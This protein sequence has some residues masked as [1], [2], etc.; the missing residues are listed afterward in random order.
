M[1]KVYINGRFLAEYLTGIQ[2][3]SVEIC[4]ALYEINPEIIVLSPNK[5]RSDYTLLGKVRKFGLLPSLF[6]EYIELPIFLFFHK[7]PLLL[8]FGSPGPL[9]YR[10]RIVSIHD[11]SYKKNPKWFTWF[12]GTYYKLITPLYARR[13]KKIITVSKFSQSEIQKWLKIPDDKFV[14]I[15]NAVSSLLS[16]SENSQP[17]VEGKYVLTVS[18]LDPRKNLH[19]VFKAFNAA[20]PK[21][22]KLIL[23][24][25]SS[26]L[27]NFKNYDDIEIE[28]IG[29]V[30]NEK[31]SNL[32]R[33]ASVFIYLSYYE[34]FGIPPLEAMSCG[35]P[36]IL[37]DIPVFREIYGDAALFVKP[38][39]IFEV[40][41][42]ID[43]ILNHEKLRKE[44]IEKGYEKVKEFDWKKSASKLNE[45]ILSIL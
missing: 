42:A 40:K 32:Y 4:N 33:N 43:L 16:G 24:G 28:S 2:R 20:P 21:G 45:I 26:P 44:L 19:T 3:F 30:S 6:W 29:Y 35:C 14:I 39:D 37:S 41:N 18:S 7:K 23:A 9:F 11:I 17:I 36:V 34:G 10:N 27:F 31:L 5:I 25:K 15:H 38:D 1:S 8:N 13:A 22:V 12:Y